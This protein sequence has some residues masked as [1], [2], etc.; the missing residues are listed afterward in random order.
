MYEEESDSNKRF[1]QKSVVLFVSIFIVDHIVDQT[2]RIIKKKSQKRVE[3]KL[4][5]Q[6]LI[7]LFDD[8]IDAYE[9]SISVRKILKNHKI[10]M[11]LLN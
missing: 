3:K 11:S 7:E 8:A 4:N 6:S 9:K 1:H 10:D 2:K 5:S